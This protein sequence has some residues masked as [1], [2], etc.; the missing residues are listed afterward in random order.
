MTLKH[1]DL[2]SQYSWL[3][4]REASPPPPPPPAIDAKIRRGLPACGEPSHKKTRERAPLPAT[5][6]R[7]FFPNGTPN[8]RRLTNAR[9]A[10]SR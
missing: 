9:A 3:K 1:T 8:I 5:L 6:K 7:E 4:E 10:R 2:V